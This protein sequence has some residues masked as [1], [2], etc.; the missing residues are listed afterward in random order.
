ML[1][2]HVTIEDIPAWVEL[3]K[4]V[5]PIF[6]APH[7]AEDPDFHEYMHGKVAKYEA[8]IAVNRV[9]NSCLGVIGFSKSHNRITWFGV[10]EK[11]RGKGVGS[12]LIKCALNQ[13]D[14]NREIT[15]ETF[16]DEFSPGAPAKR[17]Y[18]KFG[19]DDAA[20]LFDKLGNPIS[21]MVK[22]PVSLGK[23]C[24]FHLNYAKFINDSKEES[25]PV[26]LKVPGP[27]GYVE[28]KELDY[29]YVECTK[30]AQGRLFGKCHLLSKKHS[31]NFYDLSTEDMSNFMRDVQKTAKALHEVTGAVKINY[32][33]HGNTVAHLH[34]HLFPRYLDDDFPGSSINY[35][36]TEP[37][38]YESEEEFNWFVEQF[39]EKL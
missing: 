10:F 19:F 31:A 38:P 6:R 15:V 23:G 30:E 16:P 9:T 11:H 1:I 32:E 39:R 36:L 28:I 7:M 34:A 13:L 20:A 22:S 25:C 4:D 27:P 37:S 8:F 2:R 33:I 17:L 29:S 26:C 12:K 5:S 35:S 14:W 3:A 21:K 18:R 24:S